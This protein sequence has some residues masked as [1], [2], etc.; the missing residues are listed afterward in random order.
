MKGENPQKSGRTELKI[1][2]FIF[3]ISINDFTNRTDIIFEDY[4]IWLAL[5]TLVIKIT[6]L[7]LTVSAAFCPSLR[8]RHLIQYISKLKTYHS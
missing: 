5:V 1:N 4:R 6:V 2:N 3:L 7:T 8:K